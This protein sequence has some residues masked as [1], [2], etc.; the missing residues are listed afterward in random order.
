MGNAVKT[1]GIDGVCPA[2]TMQSPVSPPLYR[3]LAPPLFVRS[4]GLA[5][6]LPQ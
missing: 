2:M 1:G 5:I 4:V 6:Q 3:L